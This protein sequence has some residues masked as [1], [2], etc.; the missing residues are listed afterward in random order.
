MIPTFIVRTQRLKVTLA[1]A[2][3]NRQANKLVPSS[4]SNER[5]FD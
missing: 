1:A 4:P 2:G 5:S 3:S